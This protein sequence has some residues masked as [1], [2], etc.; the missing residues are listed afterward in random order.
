MARKD[1]NQSMYVN[2][3]EQKRKAIGNPNKNV[4]AKRNGSNYKGTQSAR[5]AAE[6]LAAMNQ[7]KESQRRKMA[8]QVKL[9]MW[10]MVILAIANIVLENTLFKGNDLANAIMMIALGISC[11]AFY[12]TRRTTNGDREQ[13]GIEKA[14]D[15]VLLLICVFYIFI[16]AMALR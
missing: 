8:P 9:S 2:V 5:T 15:V 10:I 11:G 3:A 13:S 12:Y 7:P 16:G 1:E 6:K 14:L 4:H